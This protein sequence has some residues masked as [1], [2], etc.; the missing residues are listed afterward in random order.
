MD[1]VRL[2]GEG[3]M[4]KVIIKMPTDAIVERTHDFQTDS[5]LYLVKSNNLPSC[6]EYQDE[7]F[8]ERISLRHL[9]DLWYSQ[10]K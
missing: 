10:G 4:K 6:Q 7:M 1:K 8:I 9:L 3:I 5:D 2:K